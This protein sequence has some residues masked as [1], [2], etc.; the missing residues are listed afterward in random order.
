MTHPVAPSRTSGSPSDR[1]DPDGPHVTCARWIR[2]AAGGDVATVLICVPG[3]SGRLQVAARE[4]E[5]Q[6]SLRLHADRRRAVFKSQRHFR[7]ALADPPGVS[8]AIFPLVSGGV[9]L[10]VIEVIA[11]TTILEERLDALSALV[12]RT[13]SVLESAEVHA[14]AEHSLEGLTALLRLA[15]ELLQ[16]ETATERVRLTVDACHRH[17]HIPVA[18]VMPD[19]DGWGWFLA[20][21]K[22]I[23]AR[24]RANLRQ[25]LRG[26]GGPAVHPMRPMPAAS[27][28]RQ[29]REVSGCRSAEAVRAGAVVL[30]L[31]DLPPEHRG[32]VERAST[33]LQGVV[34]RL[35][36]GAPRSPELAADEVGIAWTAHELK[37]PLAG[38]RAALDVVSDR[39]VEDED[40]QLLRKVNEEL[41]ALSNL[42]DPILRWS[43]GMEPLTLQ[44]VDLVEVS[45]RAVASSSIGSVA[46]RVSIYGPDHLYVRADPRHLQSAI[47]NVVRNSLSYAATGTPVMLRVES[48]SRTARVVVRD[49]GPGIPAQEQ[50]M[51]FSPFSRGRGGGSRSSWGSRSGSGLGLFIARRILEAHG[52]SISLR[53]TKAGATFVLELPA[54]EI[55]PVFLTN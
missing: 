16:T 11:P 28:R 55:A 36:P 52:G 38:I 41:A 40:K 42:I 26:G 50:K 22:G 6:G 48:H 34:P 21:V 24:E 7:L 17:L 47:S 9:R 35:G 13:A 39:A 29:F 15:S 53:P 30:L 14:D 12:D 31:G 5:D 3:S 49:R 46:G 27:L 23:G 25:A 4:G 32:F 8:M 45:R 2:A 1:T 33:V 19:R 10:G 18:G 43:T 44:R 51:L 54:E 37:G 20:A